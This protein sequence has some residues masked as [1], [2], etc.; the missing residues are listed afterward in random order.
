MAVALAVT[1]ISHTRRH[2][3]IEYKP[4]FS[5]N[6][7]TNGDTLDL[8]AATNPLFLPGGKPGQALPESLQVVGNPGGDGAE[9]VIGAT[10]ATHKIKM[11]SAANTELAAAA[12]N[13]AVTGD[14]NVRIVAVFPTGK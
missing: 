14:T 5:G 7:S 6:Y 11:F 12:Y 3:E 8:T 9:G 13:A 10:N 1:R 4:T 2:K